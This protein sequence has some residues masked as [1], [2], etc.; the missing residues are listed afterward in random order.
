MLVL[1]RKTNLHILYLVEDKSEKE[2]KTA[3]LFFDKV[4]EFNELNENVSDTIGTVGI[5]RF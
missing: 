5:R 3:S 4:I 1:S 2:L